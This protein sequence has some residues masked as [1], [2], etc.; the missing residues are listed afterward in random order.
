MNKKTIALIFSL[1]MIGVPIV[2]MFADMP[3][4][5]NGTSTPISTPITSSAIASSYSNTAY[6]NTTTSY[7]HNVL[8]SNSG[9]STVTMHA[10]E[11]SGYTTTSY[12]DPSQVFSISSTGA[13]TTT[14]FTVSS[15]QFWANADTNTVQLQD[16]AFMGQ[17]SDQIDTLGGTCHYVYTPGIIYVNLTVPATNGFTGGTVSWSTTSFSQDYST[18]PHVMYVDPTW[19]IFGVTSGIT[20]YGSLRVTITLQST[21]ITSITGTLNLNSWASGGSS[22]ENG[23]A[24]STDQSG[25]TY[26]TQ[27]SIADEGASV[28]YDIGYHFN[29]ASS[30]WSYSDV[31]SFNVVTENEQYATNAVY[32][33]VTEAVPYT[34]TGAVSVESITFIPEATPNLALISG[35]GYTVEY[36]ISNIE[37]AQSTSTTQTFTGAQNPAQQQNW[38]NSTLSLT[39]TD[40]S[41][42]LNNPS[43]ATTSGTINA[44]TTMTWSINHILSAGYGQGAMF[45]TVYYHGTDITSGS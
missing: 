39:L 12:S 23:V 6:V 8:Q 19:N 38:W 31:T 20:A 36:Y 35:G 21:A 28:P 32:N 7:Y 13:E 27:T 25:N 1:I 30:S 18:H 33:G 34:F 5:S 24:T 15:S 3:S 16:L 37:Q 22:S 10:A 17:Y 40:P 26:T 44:E 4:F 9:V 41:G 11:N 45:D 42:A 29:S 43:L 2:T 14:S